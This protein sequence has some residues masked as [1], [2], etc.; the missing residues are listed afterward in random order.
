MIEN[1]NYEPNRELIEQMI[2]AISECAII[3]IDYKIIYNDPN[4]NPTKNQ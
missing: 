1:V 3:T 2:N 4:R